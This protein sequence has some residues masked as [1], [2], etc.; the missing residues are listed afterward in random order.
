MNDNKELNTLNDEELEDVN[1]GRMS[2]G[3]IAGTVT[4][5]IAGAALLATAICV[6]VAKHVK[7][8]K[9]KK[10]KTS[11][12]AVASNASAG[13]TQN[14]PPAPATPIAPTIAPVEAQPVTP[15]IPKTIAP[16]E[17]QEA[18][19][20]SPASAYNTS[21]PNGWDISLLDDDDDE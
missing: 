4:G 1:A 19:N 10:N 18:S 21:E 14:N 20:V 3:V 9:S 12:N 15:I 5:A 2:S 16:V 6:P 11:T 17:A 7:K 8:K 13:T